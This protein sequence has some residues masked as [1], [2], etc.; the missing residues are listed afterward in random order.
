MDVLGKKTVV[1]ILYK[2]QENMD[3]LQSTSN[4]NIGI[5]KHIT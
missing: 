1:Y 2:E 5:K 3:L 4:F